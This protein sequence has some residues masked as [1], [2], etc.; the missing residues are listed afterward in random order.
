MR[1]VHE[2]PNR[3]TAHLLRGALEAAGVP[4]VVQGEHLAPLQGELPAGAAAQYRVCIL[5][6]EQEPIAE[7]LV[8]SWFEERRG[9]ERGVPWTCTGCGEQHETQF[10]ACWKCGGERP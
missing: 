2:T 1:C 10:A 8:E 5:D 3:T 4:A 6:S 9:L 7:R